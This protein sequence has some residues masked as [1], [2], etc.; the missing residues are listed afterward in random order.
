ML[1]HVHEVI[2]HQAYV[3][4][5][6]ALPPARPRLPVED[7]QARGQADHPQ[8]PAPRPPRPHTT[9][10]R[11]PDGRPWPGVKKRLRLRR[12]GDFQRVLGTRRVF[13]GRTLVAFA[14]PGGEPR[15]RVG[16]A[17][18]KRVRGAVTRNR[19]KRR[20]REAA[21]RALVEDWPSSEMGIGYDVVVIA[22]P[23]ALEEPQAV[24]EREMEALRERLESRRT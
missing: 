14:V 12:Q 6:E 16:V 20:L 13:A 21:R 9:V 11:A 1:S 23:G 18:S 8:P 15:L 4:A 19:A 17:V 3:P 7:A 2:G 24:V 10:G 5:Q 22:R